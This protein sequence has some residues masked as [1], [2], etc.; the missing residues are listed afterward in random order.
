MIPIEMIELEKKGGSVAILASTH[1]KTSHYY[2][3]ESQFVEVTINST[4]KLICGS[5]YR[6]P[7]TDLENFMVEY[8][9]MLREVK[10]RLK[11][12]S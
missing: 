10:K 2:S 3:F 4:K 12:L 11:M 8:K 6:P 9:Q 5:L 1:L 7:N